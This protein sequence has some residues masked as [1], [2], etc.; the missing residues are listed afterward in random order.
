MG[1][2]ND[3]LNLKKNY[4]KKHDIVILALPPNL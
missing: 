3:C 4:Q 2:E 1:T